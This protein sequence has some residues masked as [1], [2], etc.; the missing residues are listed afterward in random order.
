MDDGPETVQQVPKECS[1]DVYVSMAPAYCGIATSHTQTCSV[2]AGTV[3]HICHVGTGFVLVELCA[4]KLKRLQ[5][6][7]TR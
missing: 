5:V 3:N 7:E 1:W 2:G 4:H 6:P